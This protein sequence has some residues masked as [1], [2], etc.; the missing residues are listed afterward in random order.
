MN[1]FWR[2]RNCLSGFEIPQKTR[3]K[4]I[5]GGILVRDDWLF[6]SGEVSGRCF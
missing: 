6:E 5:I 2:Y 4:E 3:D 1:K